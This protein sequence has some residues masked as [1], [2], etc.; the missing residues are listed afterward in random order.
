MSIT[1]QI[2]RSLVCVECEKPFVFTALEQQFF[3]EKGLAN[4]PKRCHDCRVV[5][6]AYRLGKMGGTAEAQCTRCGITCCVPFVPRGHKPIYCSP[7]LHGFKG[8]DRQPEA[9]PGLPTMSDQLK[10]R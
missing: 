9:D 5:M 3:A 4:L 8:E 1:V 10:S 6:K 7:C 2:D